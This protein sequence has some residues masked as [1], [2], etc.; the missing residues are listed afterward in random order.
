MNWSWC[1]PKRQGMQTGSVYAEA[2]QQTKKCS[3]QEFGQHTKFNIFTIRILCQSY[4]FSVPVWRYFVLFLVLYLSAANRK[5]H[6]WRETWPNL[7]CCVTEF[8][9]VPTSSITISL[10]RHSTHSSIST[11]HWNSFGFCRYSALH[12]PICTWKGTSGLVSTNPVQVRSIKT[13]AS[14]ELIFGFARMN[15]W[16]KQPSIE[17]TRYRVIDVAQT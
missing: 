9:F 13:F 17:L 5:L 16:S 1:L 4:L 10:E 12:A 7:R 2:S 11:Q 8:G 14:I 3:L 6:F 15:S